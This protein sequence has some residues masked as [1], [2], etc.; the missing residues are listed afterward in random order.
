MDFEY[1]EEELLD[2]VERWDKTGLL[3]GLPIYEKQE[4][5]TVLDNVARVFLSKNVSSEINDILEITV[6]PICRRLYKRIG[7]S[8][9]VEKMV[10]DLIEA[11]QKNK[12][13]ITKIDPDEKKDPFVLFSVNFADIYEDDL[14]NEKQFNDEEYTERV[15]N[16][17]GIM[18]QILLNKN[19]V[20]FVDKTGSN[21]RILESD[22]KK[23]EKE[24]RYKNQKTAKEIFDIIIKDTN[25]GI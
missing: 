9:D 11:I 5:A 16:L 25:K 20:S 17:L 22:I 21:W 13:S 2:V 6:F 7:T 15:D 14:I 18:R 1:T 10:N 23:S 4:L 24:T 12:E 3:T 8:F 19:L